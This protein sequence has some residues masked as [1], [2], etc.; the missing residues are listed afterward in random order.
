[1]PSKS[2]KPS[3]T[4]AAPHVVVFVVYP[5]IK[6]LD[7]AGPLQVFSDAVNER[8]E[9]FYE[10]FVVSV[11]GTAV[12]TDTC[13]PVNTIPLSDLKRRKLDTLILVGGAGV[14]NAMQDEKLK[15]QIIRLSARSKRVCAVCN[16]SFLLA[17]CNLLNERSATTHWESVEQFA[18]EFPEVEV[19]PNS[20]FVQD[21]KYW[22]SAGVTAGIDMALAMV[23]E[24]LGQSIALSLA[25]SLVTF[26]VRPGGQTQF[27]TALQLQTSDK[28]SR[29]EQLH[30]WIIANLRKNLSIDQLANK[31]N[32]SPRHFSR[33]YSQET[34]RTPAKAVEVIRVEAARRMLEEG[35]VSIISVAHRCGFGDDERMRRAF[36]RVLKVSPSSY[37]KKFNVK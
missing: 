15:Q 4:Q 17:S 36:A 3:I 33:L 29:F 27:S 34:G 25:R 1:M 16:G 12:Q 13:I 7:L 30:S 19:K 20:I 11:D 8:G 6:L 28:N 26:L 2:A 5:H 22:T 10:S 14:H 31:V 37:L 21:G 32:M 35:N 23:K 18:N 9:H 24:D